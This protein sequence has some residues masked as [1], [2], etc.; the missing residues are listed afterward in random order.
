MSSILDFSREILTYDLEHVALDVLVANLEIDDIDLLKHLLQCVS[1][2]LNTQDSL[3]HYPLGM[4]IYK[5]DIELAQLLLDNGADPNHDNGSGFSW[6]ELTVF[7]ENWDLADLLRQYG[8]IDRVS[9]DVAG[10]VCQE[11]REA[12]M[13]DFLI[14]YGNHSLSAFVASDP[15]A[16]ALMER[17]GS[18]DKFMARLLLKSGAD[19][20][21]EDY[22]NQAPL[23][24]SIGVYDEGTVNFLLENGVDPNVSDSRGGLPVVHAAMGGYGPIVQALLEHGADPNAEDALGR[25]PLYVALMPEEDEGLDESLLDLLLSYGASVN[26]GHHYSKGEEDRLDAPSNPCLS[27]LFLIGTA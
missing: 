9:A 1:A 22:F 17:V 11:E 7:T 14:Q 16:H 24:G 23:F 15:L 8:A 20:T 2:N 26:K 5:G 10:S 6:L 21:R 4:A 19:W 13:L 3:G 27:Q 18:E 12:S 25:T